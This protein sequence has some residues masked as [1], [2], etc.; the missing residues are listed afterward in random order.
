MSREGYAAGREPR[1]VRGLVRLC[2]EA[3]ALDNSMR[4]TALNAAADAERYAAMR[5][6]ECF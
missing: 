4:R 2:R 6:T 5:V 1:G 3:D